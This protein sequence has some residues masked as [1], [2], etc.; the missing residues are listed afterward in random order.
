M[1]VNYQGGNY[2]FFNHSLWDGLTL[3]DIIFP[4][5]MWIMGVS[6]AYSMK[7]CDKSPKWAQVP[8]IVKRSIILFVLGIIV[9]KNWELND[10]R[11][12]GVLQRFAISYLFIALIV[13]F[14]PI[15]FSMYPFRETNFWLRV[16]FAGILPVL[17]ICLTYFLTYDNC[18]TGY[19]GPGG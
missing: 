5:F 6:C 9:N 7:N 1:F 16:M 4:F 10:F 2:E 11:I 12:M 13:L 3:A 15:H 17:S 14:F 8:R 19:T 18:P